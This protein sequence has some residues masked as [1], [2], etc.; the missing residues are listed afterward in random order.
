MHEAIIHEIST[1]TGERLTT[2]QHIIM[3]ISVTGSNGRYHT[4]RG[5]IPKEYRELTSTSKRFFIE[6]EIGDFDHFRIHA[7]IPEQEYISDSD[8]VFFINFD[9]SG[10]L[11]DSLSATFPSTS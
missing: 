11:C 4:F 9:A 7:F 5:I 8:R 3:M 2:Y 10:F 6:T 1:E